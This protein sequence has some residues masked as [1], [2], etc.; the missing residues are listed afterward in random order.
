M[1]HCSQTKTEE[2]EFDLDNLRIIK[3][4]SET[5]KKINSRH[6]ITNIETEKEKKINTKEQTTTTTLQR[7][8]SHQSMISN[9]FLN[10]RK[11]SSWKK[12]LLTTM[13]PPQ[14]EKRKK[15]KEENTLS[16]IKY[17]DDTCYT[18]EPTMFS[19]EFEDQSDDDETEIDHPEI[20]KYFE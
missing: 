8:H 6:S 2:D 9:L 7:H 17:V 16:N 20:M 12:G 19:T 4:L 11:T 14:E 13:S 1:F 18:N 5:K 3:R 15:S 10:L